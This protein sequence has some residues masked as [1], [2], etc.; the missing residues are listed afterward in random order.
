MKEYFCIDFD[1]FNEMV[2]YS[3]VEAIKR[4]S[5]LCLA[6]FMITFGCSLA[7][8]AN[9]GGIPVSCPPYVLSCIEGQSLTLG[10]LTFIMH[11]DFILN[12]L[13]MSTLSTF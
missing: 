6:L 8:R 11:L 7:I 4:Y 1:D 12:T 10:T 9:T 3:K 13:K 2:F 5:I